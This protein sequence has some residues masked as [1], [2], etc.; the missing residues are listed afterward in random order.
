MIKGVTPTV[1]F[2]KIVSDEL[3]A[4]MGGERFVLEEPDDGPQI[5]LMAGLQGVGKTTASAKIAYYLQQREN[6]K[7]PANNRISIFVFSAG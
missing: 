4:L 1:Q 7:V 6:R 3:T 5:V 2:V